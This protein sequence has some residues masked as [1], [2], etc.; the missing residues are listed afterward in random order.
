MQQ[1]AQPL[2]GWCEERGVGELNARGLWFG[3]WGLTCKVGVQRE[4]DARPCGVARHN[5]ERRDDGQALCFRNR[6]K[7]T[8]N[9]HRLHRDAVGLRVKFRLHVTQHCPQRAAVNARGG[10]KGSAACAS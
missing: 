10:V 6:S 3:C 1:S 5:S 4:A 2:Q 8:G 9:G 7:R